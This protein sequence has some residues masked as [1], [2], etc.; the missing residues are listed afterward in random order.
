[1]S[2]T[3]CMYARVRSDQQTQALIDKRRPAA[4]RVGAG[5]LFFSANAPVPTLDRF[6]LRAENRPAVH[7]CDVAHCIN[8]APR[9]RAARQAH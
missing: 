6:Q 7:H 1:M 2:R 3:V 5:V 8:P 4:S 9:A